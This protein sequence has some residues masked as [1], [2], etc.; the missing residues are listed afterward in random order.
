MYSLSCFEQASS[1]AITSQQQ[2]LRIN[3]NAD[4]SL[5]CR[6]FEAMNTVNPVNV[7]ML[8]CISLSLSLSL[9]L[10][11]WFCCLYECNRTWGFERLFTKD[12]WLGHCCLQRWRLMALRS[13]PIPRAL[14]PLHI[15]RYRDLPTKAGALMHPGSQ[16]RQL[17]AATVTRVS[18]TGITPTPGRLLSQG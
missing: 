9:Y 18:L 11:L 17:T 10:F 12:A 13:L 15:R 5:L 14:E 2:A 4:A 6:H 7:S 3:M 1:H 8:V 16:G